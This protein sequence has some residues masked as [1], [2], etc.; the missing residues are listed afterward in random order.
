MSDDLVSSCN[1]AVPLVRGVPGP[2]EVSSPFVWE[3]A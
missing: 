3:D 1:Q 2:Q